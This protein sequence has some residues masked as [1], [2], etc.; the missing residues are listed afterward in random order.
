MPSWL[1][2]GGTCHHGSHSNACTLIRKHFQYLRWNSEKSHTAR[3]NCVF[4][5]AVECIS[6]V[7]FWYVLPPTEVQV[8]H[9]PLVHVL[10]FVCLLVTLQNTDKR[11]SWNF[12]DRSKMIQ[13]TI[14]Y[15]KAPDH[16]VLHCMSGI[17]QNVSRL[18][19]AS[20]TRCGRNVLLGT[21]AMTIWCCF[22]VLYGNYLF[23]WYPLT[24]VRLSRDG[25]A[26]WGM[27][28]L[29]DNI[30]FHS[31]FLLP[32]VM[33]GLIYTLSYCGWNYVYKYKC[34]SFKLL[35]VNIWNFYRSTW[36]SKSAEFA[37][38]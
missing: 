4:E 35:S 1:V 7:D 3:R 30:S 12:Q 33:M 9:S 19:S 26:I 28:K 20:S 5:N 38:I 14:I 34:L 11:I 36:C 2:I 21:F 8:I 10:V 6:F 25:D 32:V 16:H 37:F 31:S 23:N 17:G 24:A 22:W 13:G 15:K 27:M 18:S 29:L